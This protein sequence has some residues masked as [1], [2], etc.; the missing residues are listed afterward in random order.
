MLKKILVTSLLLS[1]LPLHAFAEPSPAYEWSNAL[2]LES[3]TNLDGGVAEGTRSLANLDLTLAI[4]TQAA[5]WW[6]N[7]AVFIYVL[8]NYGKAPSDLTGDL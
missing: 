3:V 7:G 5:G 4:D 6:E 8:G 2:T 1:F